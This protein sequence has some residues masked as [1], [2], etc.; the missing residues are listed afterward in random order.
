[1]EEQLVQPIIQSEPKDDTQLLWEFGIV[2][3]LF[4]LMSVLAIGLLP[5]SGF[6]R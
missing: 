2:I 4:I 5:K 3:A 1:M 6:F